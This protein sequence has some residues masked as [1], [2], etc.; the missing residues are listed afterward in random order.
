MSESSDLADEKRQSELSSFVMREVQR[1]LAQWDEA[2]RGDKAAVPAS[3]S[4]SEHLTAVAAEF[5]G[6]LEAEAARRLDAQACE[7]ASRPRPVDHPLG[8]PLLKDYP[9]EGARIA[10]WPV[11]LRG[12]RISRDVLEY[13]DQHCIGGSGTMMRLP[14]AEA[15]ASMYFPWLSSSTAGLCQASGR[16]FLDLRSQTGLAVADQSLASSQGSRSCRVAQGRHEHRSCCV[17]RP[18]CFSD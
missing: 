4:A 13:R 1:I 18:G 6:R 16:S 8:H 9:R 7:I 11:Q 2:R 14:F 5:L 15:P 3:G 10:E 12:R 17:G